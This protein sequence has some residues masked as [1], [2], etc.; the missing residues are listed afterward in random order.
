MTKISRRIGLTQRKSR[1][2]LMTM[3]MI[4]DVYHSSQLVPT[5]IDRIRKRWEKKNDQELKEKRYEQDS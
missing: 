5:V 3:V 2:I 1:D 4:K